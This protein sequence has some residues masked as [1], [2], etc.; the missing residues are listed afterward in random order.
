M[1]ILGNHD[2]GERYPTMGNFSFERGELTWDAEFDGRTRTRAQAPIL[3][4]SGGGAHLHL[5]GRG[6][7]LKLK[8]Y[9]AAH[10]PDQHS[11]SVLDIGERQVLFRQVGG[12]GRELD[13]FVL[14]R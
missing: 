6:Q 13:R 3:V 11:L 4:V 1:G 12:D 10:Q 14:T 5:K 8:P 9:L 7:Q 2:V